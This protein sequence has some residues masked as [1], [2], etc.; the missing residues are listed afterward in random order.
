MAKPV[1]DGLEQDLEGKARV[2]RL[3]LLSAVG[4]QA[5]SRYGVR[6]VPTLLVVDGQGEVVYG[7]AGIPS[8]GEV[9]AEVKTLLVAETKME[10]E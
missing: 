6:A 4:Q 3:D 5:A 8:P 9:K 7:Q 1:V 2:I 10:V